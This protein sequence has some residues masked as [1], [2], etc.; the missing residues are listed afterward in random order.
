MA[1]KSKIS[2]QDILTVS[3][4]FVRRNGIET[5]NARTLANLLGCSTQPIFSNYASM[6]MLKQDIEKAAHQLYM[7][8]IHAEISKQEYPEYKSMG[9]AYIR[10]AKE[11][12]ELFKLLFMCERPSNPDNFVP[13]QS[14]QDSLSI[15]RNANAIS[16]NQANQLHSKMWIFVHGIATML[17][18]SYLSWEWDTIS[19]MLTDVYVGLK[20]VY[21]SKED[22]K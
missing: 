7:E 10:F 17:A 20:E 9:M 18:T 16:L 8:Y 13:E 12:K 22:I 11:E 6:D 14:Y 2:K 19:A 15:I 3:T 21:V 4:D 1:P 5:L